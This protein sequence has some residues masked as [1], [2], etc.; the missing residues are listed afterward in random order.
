MARPGRGRSAN[1]RKSLSSAVI[2][3][4]ELSELLETAY[5]KDVS[6]TSPRVTCHGYKA[7]I[8]RM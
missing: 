1:M 2:D 3:N 7:R 8:V 4:D 5:S 6:M